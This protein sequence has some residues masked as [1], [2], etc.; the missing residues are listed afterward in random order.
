[1]AYFTADVENVFVCNYEMYFFSTSFDVI[2]PYCI[3]F[4]LNILYILFTEL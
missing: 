2:K 4:F 3:K 1:M